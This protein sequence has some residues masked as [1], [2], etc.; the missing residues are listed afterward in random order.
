MARAPGRGSCL[1]ARPLPRI[2]RPRRA[3]FV[4]APA[5]S[6][7]GTTTRTTLIGVARHSAPTLVE[8]TL[9]PTALFYACWMTVGPWPAYLSALLWGF[10]ALLRRMR[11][12]LRVAGLLVVA[13]LGLT[14]R[15][16]L[17][18]AP[19][20]AFVYFAQPILATGLV[21]LVFLIS[22]ATRRPFV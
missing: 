2:R 22:A 18:L 11:R 5:V 8:A 13:L 1:R 17:A 12:G 21:A 3:G 4:S 20:S 7:A 16:V 9:V 15:S 19:G 10:S 6:L 14:V